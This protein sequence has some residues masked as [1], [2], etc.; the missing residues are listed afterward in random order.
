MKMRKDERKVPKPEI[1]WFDLI[2]GYFKWSRVKDDYK[3]IVEA[4]GERLK[5][6][7]VDRTSNFLNQANEYLLPKHKFIFDG[8]TSCLRHLVE[9]KLISIESITEDRLRD[10]MLKHLYH[11]EKIEGIEVN[12]A[13]YSPQALFCKA[14]VVNLHLLNDKLYISENCTHLIEMFETVTGWDLFQGKIEKTAMLNTLWL[15]LAASK[16][17]NQKKANSLAQH[18]QGKMLES[19]LPDYPMNQLFAKLQ[20]R[21]DEIVLR[22]IPNFDKKHP[23][24]LAVRQAALIVLYRTMMNY[25]DKA[26]QYPD[27][28]LGTGIDYMLDEIVQHIF[29]PELDFQGWFLKYFYRELTK[30]VRLIK[31]LDKENVISPDFPERRVIKYLPVLDNF[32]F[33]GEEETSLLKVLVPIFQSDQLSDKEKN[34]IARQIVF[35]IQKLILGIAPVDRK[36]EKTIKDAL[37]MLIISILELLRTGIESKSKVWVKQ[38]GDMGEFRKDVNQTISLEILDLILKYDAS[39]NPSFFGYIIKMQ[40]L[41]VKTKLRENKVEAETETESDGYNLDSF[42]DSEGLSEGGSGI[43]KALD[44]DQLQELIDNC[45]KTLTP[46][47][48]KVIEKA[49]FNNEKLT[50]TERRMKDRAL[51]KLRENYPELEEFLYEL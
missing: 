23:T 6:E 29:T 12:P 44:Q 43:E 37:E 33:M 13:R 22:E 27:I 41:Q 50:D 39:I 25:S 10:L 18:C 15:C 30:R 2:S 28:Q 11:P 51:Q 7:T 26:V 32:R 47:Q 5:S 49:Y 38:K 14:I 34:E 20:P 31:V 4:M 48:R 16:P 1:D 8:T 24:F 45:L 40:P 19:I 17:W 9:N 36:Y 3:L 46:K 21:I 42:S 35:N